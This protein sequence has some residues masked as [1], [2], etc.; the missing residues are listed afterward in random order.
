MGLDIQIGT[1]MPLS[2]EVL[3]ADDLREM[4]DRFDPT[5]IYISGCTFGSEVWDLTLRRD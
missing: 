4:I 1:D 2:G 5:A 3:K